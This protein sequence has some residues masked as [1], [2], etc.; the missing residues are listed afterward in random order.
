MITW[1]FPIRLDINEKRDFLRQFSNTV[2]GVTAKRLHKSPKAVLTEKFIIFHPIYHQSFGTICIHFF[3]FS[4]IT[5]DSTVSNPVAAQP[6]NTAQSAALPPPPQAALQPQPPP[7]NQSVVL[8]GSTPNMAGSS[9]TSTVYYGQSVQQPQPQVNYPP[10]YYYPQPAAVPPPPVSGGHAG[11]PQPQST[12]QGYP[13]A[14]YTY[15]EYTSPPPAGP[16]QVPTMMH[17]IDYNLDTGNSVTGAT[18]VTV[19]VNGGGH[20]PP[21][22]SA[23]PPHQVGHG[24]PPVHHPVHHGQQN[25]GH[26]VMSP[27]LTS[28]FS[29]SGDCKSTE[30]SS[31]LSAASYSSGALNNSGHSYGGYSDQYYGSKHRNYY[32]HHNNGGQSANNNSYHDQAPAWNHYQNPDNHVN[33]YNNNN[34]NYVSDYHHTSPNSTGSTGCSSTV[35]SESKI[36]S[37]NSNQSMINS[38]TNSSTNASS[39]SVYCDTCQIAFPS[40]AVLENHLKGSRH[41]RRVK[42]QQAFRQLKDAGTLFRIRGSATPVTDIGMSSGAIRCE[43]CQVSVNSSHQLQAHLTGKNT[44]NFFGGGS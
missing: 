31:I 22:S 1:H 15:S 9:T 38:S 30:T 3:F 4:C 42:S 10:A 36:N 20:L 29:G 13:A 35:N 37:N 7:V 40:M 41:A 25:G 27:S 19:G 8:P 28:G 17:M 14:M 24:H 6:S 21:V 18:G 34:N 44:F 39:S 5:A 32:Y 16:T 11:Q 23:M 33:Y 43:V 2:F 12:P 26:G